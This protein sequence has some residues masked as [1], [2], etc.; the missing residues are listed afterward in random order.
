MS[1]QLHIS[2]KRLI[3][4]IRNGESIRLRDEFVADIDLNIYEDGSMDVYIGESRYTNRKNIDNKTDRYREILFEVLELF[5]KELYDEFNDWKDADDWLF[6]NLTLTESDVADIYR[7]RSI[8]Y[9][10]SC[11][12]KE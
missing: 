9:T 10:T 4:E 7:G 6:S 1:E 12:H 5:R 11:K 3:D 2:D 8:V